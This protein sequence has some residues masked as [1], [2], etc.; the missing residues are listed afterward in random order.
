MRTIAQKPK[1]TQQITPPKSTV[2]GR[3]HFGPRYERNSILHLQ[4]TIGNQGVQR[5]LKANADELAAGSA[6]VASACFGHDFSQMPLYPEARTTIQPK[7]TVSPCAAR[8]P[9]PSYSRVAPMVQG[10]LDI[11]SPRDPAELEADRVADHVVGTS[12]SAVFAAQS[13]NHNVLA[14]IA[15]QDSLMRVPASSMREVSEREELPVDSM[16]VPQE[17]GNVLIQRNAEKASSPGLAD[18][19]ASMQQAIHVGGRALGAE[20]R[21]YMEPRFGLDF[22]SIRVHDDTRADRLSRSISA[23]AFTHGNQLFFSRG[24]YQP[25]SSSGRHL[26]AHELTHT[27][28]QRISGPSGVYRIQRRAQPRIMRAPCTDWNS[29]NR[30]R[31][32]DGPNGYNCA[33]LALRNYRIISPVS[34]V[35]TA[36]YNQGGAECRACGTCP[37][38]KVNY[39]L[40]TYTLSLSE[41][42]GGTLIPYY[43]DDDFHIVGGTDPSSVYSKNGGRP[44][45]GPSAGSR[46]RPPARERATT[47]DRHE[48]PVTR[49]GNP[50]I[51]TRTGIAEDCGCF[52]CT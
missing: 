15:H 28:Q 9:V 27:V 44:V 14:K 52:D 33:G 45:Y 23:K 26:L 38:G 43:Q 20:I 3:G 30:S 40:W 42:R 1:A 6:T 51:K 39:W 29:Y 50:V 2:P 36:I 35:E 16:V 11:S 47:S 48:R 18:F 10:K 19:D 34:A 21:S 22:S 49:N 41:N 12:P 5:L 25:E 7:L 24:S 46:W 17:E 31:V 8:V 13:S 32:I 4:R 37:V